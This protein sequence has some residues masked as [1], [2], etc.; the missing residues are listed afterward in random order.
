MRAEIKRT[1][2]GWEIAFVNGGEVIDR[3]EVDRID[4]KDDAFVEE[5]V[6]YWIESMRNTFE[7]LREK[8]LIARRRVARC[9]EGSL[10]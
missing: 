7:K 1:K 2:R 3:Y 10:L 4:V 9:A 8:E 6:G 5:I